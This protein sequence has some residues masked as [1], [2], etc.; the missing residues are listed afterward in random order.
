MGS[1]KS[2]KPHN[3]A[4][5]R[6]V[7]SMGFVSFF[8]DFSTEMILGILPLFIVNNLGASRAILG[9]IE[10][11]SELISYAFRL[12]SGSLSDKLGKRK[13]FV[14]IGYGIS[15]VIKPFFAT[16]ISWL[17]AFIIRATDR[18]GKGLRTA[19]RDAL[20]A[21]SVSE[22]ISGKAFGIHR[23]IDQM[24]AILGPIIAF[25]LLQIMDIRGIFFVSLIPGAIAVLILILFVNE[26]AIKRVRSKTATIFSNIGTIMSNNKPFVLLLIISGIFSLGAFNFSFVLL[27]ASE[28][29][30]DN[31]A[32]PIIYAVI[33][34]SHTAIGIPSGILADKIGK[35]KVLIVGYAVF[36]ISSILMTILSENSLYAFVLAAIFGLYIGISETVQRAVVPRYVSS[37]LRGTAFGVYNVVLGTSFF[38]SNVVFGFLWDNYNLSTA[39]VYSIVLTSVAITGMSVFIKREA[40]K[41]I[42]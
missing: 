12:F 8:T 29:G 19:P 10:G 20:I 40:K 27:K 25:A 37:E 11:S 23:T 39:V 21:D 9:S 4:G 28:L 14:L 32:I 33:N 5:L 42:Q 36:A 7:V 2:S 16:S 13:I 34:I 17:D 38:V 18:I 6:N 31:D 26:I 1:E 15:T 35:E 24:G 22:S 30:I 3:P 41:V